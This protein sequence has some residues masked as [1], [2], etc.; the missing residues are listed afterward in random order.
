METDESSIMPCP[1]HSN[2]S[3]TAFCLR[4]GQTLCIKC[5]LGTHKGC[6][7]GDNV[8]D[9]GETTQRLKKEIPEAIR[10]Y[11]HLTSSSGQWREKYSATLEQLGEMESRLV[12]GIKQ[13]RFK[14]IEQTNRLA[15]DAL[16][17]VSSLIEDQRSMVTHDFAQLE[18]MNKQIEGISRSVNRCKETKDASFDDMFC[19]VRSVKRLNS[20]FEN[21][22][23]LDRNVKLHFYISDELQ[24]MRNN[25]RSF[26]EL[27]VEDPNCRNTG[28]RSR[29]SKVS[30]A[31]SVQ[32]ENISDDEIDSSVFVLPS[33]RPG[34]LNEQSIYCSI[35]VEP[36]ASCSKPPPLPDMHPETPISK[37]L[38]FFDD[39]KKFQTLPKMRPAHLT[40]EA[41]KNN[42]YYNGAPLSIPALPKKRPRSGS[43]EHTNDNEAHSNLPNTESVLAHT[44]DN[45]LNDTCRVATVHCCDT[46]DAFENRPEIKLRSS[47]VTENLAKIFEE[48]GREEANKFSPKPANE[49]S[50]EQNNVPDL[51][52][53]K[54]DISVNSSRDSGVG[55]NGEDKIP[56][57]PKMHKMRFSLNKRV[58]ALASADTSDASRYSDN[59]FLLC[60]NDISSYSQKAMSMTDLSGRKTPS[61]SKFRLSSKS[62]VDSNLSRNSCVSSS[63]S[64][65]SSESRSIDSSVSENITENKTHYLKN[66]QTQMRVVTPLDTKSRQSV[67]FS[68]LASLSPKN[69]I[70]K[71]PTSSHSKITGVAATKSGMLFI[72]DMENNCLQLFDNAGTPLFDYRIKEPFSCCT[73]RDEEVA[74]TSKDRKSLCI[75][76]ISDAKIVCKEE[77]I[78]S[79]DSEVYG[80][81]YSK[82][83]VGVCCG[84]CVVVL[85]ESLQPYRTV[86]PIVMLKKKKA[87][88][89]FV[90]VRYIAMEWS[91][92]GFFIYTSENKIDRVSCIVVGNRDRPV[93]NCHVGKPNALVIYKDNVIVAAK[94]KLVVLE[95]ASGQRLREIHDEVPSHPVHMTLLDDWLYISKTSSSNTE[96]RNIRKISLISKEKNRKIRGSNMNMI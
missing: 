54:S 13:L 96:S 78:V 52:A 42:S 46:T 29:A 33:A 12:D 17:M 63:A 82:G 66:R 27:C 90:E 93:W 18:E 2:E 70:Q 28:M 8:E 68:L 24:F 35:H 59:E 41:K 49:T 21:T 1:V 85:T 31:P 81:G 71:N 50:R 48:K 55:I 16:E 67:T 77:Q 19:V 89:Y 62:S 14:M 47:I 64:V 7:H 5:L 4:H 40:T 65:L 86:K 88:P 45:G 25:L 94:H 76:N 32:M 92:L 39:A 72:C 11:E 9:I 53:G 20:E 43:S 95:A 61:I 36:T 38:G 10:T 30:L 51:A 84:D 80:V 60:T 15:S 44:S 26:G 91:K 56:P 3:V 23:L 87:K 75:F 34:S 73:I 57:L 37:R 69:D 83:F 74:V 6:V 58:E 22:E 79:A